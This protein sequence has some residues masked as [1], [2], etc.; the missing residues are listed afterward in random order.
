[1]RIIVKNNKNVHNPYASIMSFSNFYQ[2][3]YHFLSK[4]SASLS[5]NKH[6]VGRR[7][8]IT[9]EK[10]YVC[11][12]RGHR[13]IC[14]VMLSYL[15]RFYSYFQS[16]FLCEFKFAIGVRGWS[17]MTWKFTSSCE[18][19]THHQNQKGWNYLRMFPLEI[20]WNFRLMLNSKH[21]HGFTQS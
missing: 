7:N 16:L 14:S 2:M 5:I 1:M 8:Y 18:N 3:F 15:S 20:L 13:I 17:F 4:H 19:F 12:I 6:R 10:L 9:M 11:M 21:F